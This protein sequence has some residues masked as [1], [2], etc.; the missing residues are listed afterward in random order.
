MLQKNAGDGGLHIYEIKRSWQLAMVS[1]DEDH[2]NGWK[3]HNLSLNTDEIRGLGNN[4]LIFSPSHKN[5]VP[6]PHFQL[7]G[8][9]M[10]LFVCTWVI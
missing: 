6:L 10:W 9:L 1:P 3:R 8:K 4:V 2:D 7:Y 5:R